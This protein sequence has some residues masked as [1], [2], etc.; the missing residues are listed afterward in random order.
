MFSGKIPQP[1]LKCK[2]GKAFEK[3]HSPLAKRG[4]SE[5]SERKNRGGD[6]KK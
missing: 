2:A 1:S 5:I 3:V 6:R 4:K